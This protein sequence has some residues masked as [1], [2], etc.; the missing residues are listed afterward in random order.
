LVIAQSKRDLFFPV[1]LGE[2]TW[3]QSLVNQTAPSRHV[4]AHMN[5]LSKDSVTALGVRLQQ[6]HTHLQNR[7]AEIRA[8]MVPV[9]PAP[10]VSG[11]I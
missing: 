2:E 10:A 9:T 5:P 4:L 11:A 1:I 3:F 8:A 7:E 6:W